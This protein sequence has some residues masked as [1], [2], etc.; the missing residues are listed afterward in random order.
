MPLFPAGQVFIFFK[1]YLKL[2][3]KKVARASEK[4]HKCRLKPPSFKYNLWRSM[5]ITW[6]YLLLMKLDST[7]ILI[8]TALIYKIRS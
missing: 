5:T 8:I 4:P 3:G 7:Y 6:F 2:P 1:V